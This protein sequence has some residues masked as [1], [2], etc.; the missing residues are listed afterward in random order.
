LSL[1]QIEYLLLQ[2]LKGSG[3]EATFIMKVSVAFKF[4]NEELLPVPLDPTIAIKLAIKN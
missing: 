3:L 1:L 2:P 4:L